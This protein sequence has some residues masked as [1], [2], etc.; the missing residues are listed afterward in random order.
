MVKLSGKCFINNQR[1]ILKLTNGT[2]EIKH[3]VNVLNRSLNSIEKNL[4][5]V[6]QWDFLVTSQ[7]NWWEAGDNHMTFWMW[8]IAS[9]QEFYHQHKIL[10]KEISEKV[11]RISHQ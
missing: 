3:L 4:L 2:T 10:K 7:Q 8:Q 6:Q 11:Q 1:E 5:K 9:N